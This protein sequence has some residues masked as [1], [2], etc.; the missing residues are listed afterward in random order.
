MENRIYLDNAATTKVDDDILQEV[1]PYF[2]INYGNAS[3]VCKE[4]RIAKKIIDKSRCFVADLINSNEDEIYFTSG[5]S[6]SD[7]WAIRGLAEKY[8]TK[9]HIITSKIEHKAILNVCEYMKTKG[10]DI[11]YL[12]VDE[13]GFVSKTELEE[14]IRPDTL[15]VS[16][17]YANNEIGTI[18]DIQCLCDI[19]HK[20]NVFFHTD[21]VQILGKIDINVKKMGIDMMS[22]SAHKIHGFKGVGA[23]Y[24]NKSINIA[25]LI[26]GG[27][28]ES[29]K[30]AGTYNVAGIYSLGLAC[31]KLTENTDEREYIRK[32]RDYLIDKVLTTIP[33]AKLTGDSKNRLINN[34]HFCFKNISSDA[35][36]VLLDKNNISASA[37]SACMSGSLEKSHVLS[38]L[39]ISD[40]YI[41]GNIRLTLSKY[42]NF[43]QIDIV[44]DRLSKIIN[45]Q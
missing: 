1:L 42:N 43:E 10:Y 24:I 41:D 8:P 27:E 9:K 22:L 31:K 4:S 14:S 39:G 12:N 33:S 16:I 28:Q 26:I 40:D 2:N 44:V 13:H 3:G 19:S 15:L 21:A 45:N 5:G 20:K 17:M 29:G 38:A 36:L 11:T 7:N 37:G 6:E 32:M 34:V 18:Q 30:R 25:P 23:L 35:I